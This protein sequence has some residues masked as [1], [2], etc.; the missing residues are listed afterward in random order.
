MLF[1]AAKATT[2]RVATDSFMTEGGE[3]P[4]FGMEN[5]YIR[6]LPLIVI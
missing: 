3:M 5:V 6:C 4:D 1:V 2:V